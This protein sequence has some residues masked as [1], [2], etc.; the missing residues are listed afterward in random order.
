MGSLK[1]AIKSPSDEKGDYL[2]VGQLAY[3]VV[4]RIVDHVLTKIIGPPQRL[5]ITSLTNL[6]QALNREQNFTQ[7]LRDDANMKK[8][9]KTCK[10]KWA[11]QNI[12][13]DA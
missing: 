1:K 3:E 13:I 2:M 6:Q 11:G 5:F 7:P 9:G 10:K 8:D 12:I 4:R